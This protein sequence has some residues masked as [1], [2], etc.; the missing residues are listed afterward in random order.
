MIYG[1]KEFVKKQFNTDRYE[2]RGEFPMLHAG[3]ECDE[4]VAMIQVEDVIY[5]VGSSHGSPLLLSKSDLLGKAREYSDVL[6]K[7]LAAAEYLD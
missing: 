6:A 3:W 7:T 1:L 5:A 2:L 4:T